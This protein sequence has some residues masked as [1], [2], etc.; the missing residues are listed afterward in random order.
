MPIGVQTSAPVAGGAGYSSSPERPAQG[1]LRWGLEAI[2]APEAWQVTEGADDIVVAVI[3]SGV[4]RRVPFLASRMWHNPGEIPGNGIDDDR[5]GYV[6]D[7]YGW[8]FQDGDPDSLSGSSLNWHGTFV[9][10]LI[11]AAVDTSSGVGGVAPRVRLMDV[12]FLDSKGV[13]YTSD[14]GRLARAIDYAVDNGARIINLSIYTALRPPKFV[15][16]AIRRAVEKGVLVVT[17]AGNQGADRVSY[18]GRWPEVITVGAVDKSG[19][20]ASFSNRGREVDLAGPGVRVLSLVPGGRVMA[21]SGTSFAAPHVAGTAALLLSL[22]PDMPLS[23]LTQL[24][25]RTA[26]DVGPRGEDDA[27]GWGLVNAG[28]AVLQAAST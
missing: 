10:G 9:A 7:V 11:A 16:S 4:D 1:N 17:I 22:H 2:E 28:E 21:A 14:W 6:D 12:R 26:R 24:L 27:T 8:D 5:N 25:M 13:F 20:P 15:H 23:E 3:D 18:F 19:R